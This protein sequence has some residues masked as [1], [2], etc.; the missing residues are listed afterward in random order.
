MATG[1]LGCK[2]FLRV[3]KRLQ[4]FPKHWA[5]DW[6]G[7]RRRESLLYEFGRNVIM[8][9]KDGLDP[10]ISCEGQMN[11]NWMILS[12]IFLQLMQEFL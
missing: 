11:P 2:R 7:W 3:A 4:S 5:S 10:E 9:P 6:F 8:R 1:S 12:F